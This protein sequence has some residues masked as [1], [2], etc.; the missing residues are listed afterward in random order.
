MKTYPELE[1]AI[2][3]I[4]Y[5]A[6][7][8]HTKAKEQYTAS[9]STKVF[10]QY[11]IS[12]FHALQDLARIAGGIEFACSTMKKSLELLRKLYADEPIISPEDVAE[13]KRI[14]DESAEELFK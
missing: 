13:A 7:I 8:V 11:G 1:N 6:G 3:N 2:K 12:Q 14:V 10:T 5:Y 4:E 9:I